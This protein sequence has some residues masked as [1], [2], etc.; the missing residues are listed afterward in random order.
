M[1]FSW[2]PFIALG[3][4]LFLVPFGAHAASGA[5][6]F[7]TESLW[8]SRAEAEAGDTLTIYSIVR[9]SS[10]TSLE[11]VV[12][13]TVDGESLARESLS[14]QSGGASLL[15]A[16]WRAE[17]GTHTFGAS[18]EDVEGAEIASAAQVSNTATLTVAEPPP[19]PV[20]KY[21]EGAASFIASTSPAVRTVASTV[22]GATERVREHGVEWL[23]TALSAGE[24]RESAAP[25]AAAA[26]VAA[27]S[28]A[29][30]DDAGGRVLGEVILPEEGGAETGIASTVKDRVL[31]ALLFI[32]NVKVLFYAMLVV[33]LYA[34]YKLVQGFFRY[35]Y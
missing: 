18:L 17:G 9:N 19:S 2:L 6:G 32:F 11:G 29:A 22:F 24:M 21:A 28:A 30:S 26:H 1:R 10:D 3:I 12:V 23:S 8:L 15:S 27:A 13:F 25:G 5:V 20:E 7:A 34:L 33:V 4:L 31:R 35:R 16:E 14:L